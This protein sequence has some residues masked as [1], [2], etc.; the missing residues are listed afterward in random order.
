MYETTD[1]RFATAY[2]HWFFLLQPSLPEC[3]ISSNPQAYLTAACRFPRTPSTPCSPT[4]AEE[5][6]NAAYLAN[7]SN[8]SAVHAMCEDYRASAPQ[9]PDLTLDKKD[10]EEG[11]KVECPVRV[12]WGKKGVIQMMYEGGLGLW[13][14][15][16]R[17]VEGEGVDCGHYIP[18]EAPESVVRVVEEFFP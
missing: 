6:R 10:R 5:W 3:C 17:Q 13:K 9:G 12:L 1:S 15:Q 8:P 4:A 7:L 14:Q 11:K 16:C 2:W 18:E